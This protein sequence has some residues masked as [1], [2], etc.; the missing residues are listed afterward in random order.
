[1]KT[2]SYFALCIFGVISPQQMGQLFTQMA[3]LVSEQ[4][5]LITR[6]EDDVEAG[7][8]ETLEAQGHLQTVHD[9]TKGNRGLIIKIF[10]L[11]LF[12]IFLFLVW[13]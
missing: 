4:S 1:M 6:I 3:T 9:I 5:E 8:Q 11:L 12:F 13:T 2:I 7:L 10:L